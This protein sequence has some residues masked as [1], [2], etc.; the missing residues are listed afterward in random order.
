[1]PPEGSLGQSNKSGFVHLMG[2]KYHP[3][4]QPIDYWFVYA[5]GMIDVVA[6]IRTLNTCL[7][8]NVA[9]HRTDADF[10]ETRFNSVIGCEL[11]FLSLYVCVYNVRIHK[12]NG[13]VLWAA[14][15]WCACVYN[16]SF[17]AEITSCVCLFCYCY[18][19]SSVKNLES[20]YSEEV[21]NFKNIY[22]SPLHFTFCQV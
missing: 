13:L 16:S 20:G 19:I 11:S 17:T 10:T 2:G 9:L 5:A 14:A 1:M 6:P 18:L 7:F 4:N 3:L 22:S 8:C 12:N 21:H 15:V